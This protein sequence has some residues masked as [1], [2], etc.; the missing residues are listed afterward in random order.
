MVY[1]VAIIG[2]GLAGAS[3][4]CALRSQGFRI[5]VI[6][7]APAPLLPDSQFSA[8]AIALSATSLQYLNTLGIVS[9]IEAYLES[10]QALH[11]S[12]QGCFGVTRIAAKQYGM[13]ALGAVIEADRLNYALN[14]ALEQSDNIDLFRSSNIKRLNR[15]S[16]V[17]QIILADETVLK[18]SLIV[19]ADGSDSFL[20]TAQGI[21]FSAKT[22]P[23]T[24]IVVNVALAQSHQQIAFER[25][26][27][28]GS[29]AMLPFGE[30]RVK[31]V[32][33]VPDLQAQSLSTM[34]ESE[35]LQSLQDQFG[36]RLG[37]MIQ[38][39]KRISV[40][41]KQNVSENL[42]GQGWVL[43]GNAAQTIHPIAAQGFNVGLRDVAQ[44]AELLIAQKNK[45]LSLQDIELLK[46]Y[47]IKRLPDHQRVRQMT[48]QLVN[49]GIQRRLGVLLSE[50]IPPLHRLVT[51]T[52]MGVHRDLPRAMWLAAEKT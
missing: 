28:T 9:E 34:T 41:L 50:W 5:A 16:G 45:D 47:A 33:V 17:W 12:E 48:D 30:Q 19:G 35:F 8:R 46:Q 25:F 10:I 7:K 2:A 26:T 42:Y 51:Q 27:D 18:A 13:R 1:D 44:L 6:D 29:L 32:W 24:A 20:R 4:G 40:P 49:G 37:K 21:G 31:C 52:G 11:V 3:L 43:I 38:I 22:Y 15:E 36:Y 14:H 39:G 23:A